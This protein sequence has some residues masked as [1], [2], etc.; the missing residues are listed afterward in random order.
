VNF[1]QLLAFLLS[2]RFCS[3]P[4]LLRVSN[5]SCCP[6]SFSRTALEAVFVSSLDGTLLFFRFLK[7]RLHVCTPFCVFFNLVQSRFAKTS[8]DF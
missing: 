7:P 5:H 6:F 8:F 3:L 2:V 1:E 4:C